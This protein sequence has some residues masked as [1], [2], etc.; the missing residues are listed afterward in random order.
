MFHVFIF[1]YTIKAVEKI[2]VEIALTIIFTEGYYGRIVDRSSMAWKNFISVMGKFF[3][4]YCFINFFLKLTICF[5]I[6]GVIDPDYRGTIKVIL[7]NH[8]NEDYHIKRGNKIAQLIVEKCYSHI[9]IHHVGFNEELPAD[10]EV[11]FHKPNNARN[12]GGFGSTGR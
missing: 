1:Y 5:L 9:P 10:I 7:C 2:L 6:G 11:L 3:L 8:S 12:E 4:S